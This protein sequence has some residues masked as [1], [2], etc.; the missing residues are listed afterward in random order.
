MEN[1]V[2]NEIDTFW[3]R[4]KIVFSLSCDGEI[5]LMS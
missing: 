2:R 1:D 3:F 4:K 5:I